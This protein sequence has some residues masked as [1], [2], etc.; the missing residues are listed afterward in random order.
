MNIP[1]LQTI[2]NTLDRIL[3]QVY[4]SFDLPGM[5]VGVV[6]GKEIIYAKGFGFRDI[7]VQDSVTA[8]SL[9]HQASISKVFTATA[10][11]QLVEQS[12]LR[13]DNALVNY[14]PNFWLGDERSQAITIEQILSHTSGMPDPEDHDWGHSEDREDA[15]IQRVKNL[16]SLKLVHQPGQEFAYSS[17]GYDVLGALIA[18]VSEEPFATYIRNHIFEP[19]GMK[20]STFI[21]PDVALELATSPH[22]RT[23]KM[24]VSDVFPYS[25][26]Q[27]PSGTLQSSV[28]D[29]CQWAIANLNGFDLGDHRN[30]PR[31]LS[32]ESH[33]LLWQPRFSTGHGSD[34][35]QTAI[36][37]GWFI[38]DYKGMPV[39]MHDGGDVGYE[40]EIV[41]L[42]EQS[43]AVIVMANIFPA[44]TTPITQAVLDVVLGIAVQTPEPPL[45]LS[46]LSV[47]RNDGLEAAATQFWQSG[48]NLTD[49]DKAFLRDSIFILQEADR[50]ENA[51]ELTKLGMRLYPENEE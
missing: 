42:P 6:R 16:R 45:M 19:L 49:T 2:D 10:V 18:E 5:A 21:K 51:S 33:Q 11:L 44:I 22:I 35:R 15:L 24:T 27:V 40:A 14:L 20:D 31:I 36:G 46:M 7:R 47:L 8:R 23:P 4:Q 43:V 38:G 41:L 28:L 3:E 34:S 17:L 50:P 13:L 12:Q 32:P 26:S 9:F 29:M 39:V 25:R 48:Q 37:L 30:S 1:N